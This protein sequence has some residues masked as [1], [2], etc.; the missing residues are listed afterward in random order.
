MKIERKRKKSFDSD[1]NRKEKIIWLNIVPDMDSLY[2]MIQRYVMGAGINVIL[3]I[4]QE[5]MLGN[6]L[7]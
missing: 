2:R 3:R 6:T 7:L 4:H 1:I 5:G